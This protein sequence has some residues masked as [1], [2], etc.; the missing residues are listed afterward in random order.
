MGKVTKKTVNTLMDVYND[1]V[2]DTILLTLQNPADNNSVVAEIEVKNQLTIAEKGA[3]V[4]RVVNACFDEDGEYMPEYL[5]PAFAITL[6]QMTTKVPVYEKTIQDD[7]GNDMSIVDIGRTFELCKAINLVTN[8]KDKV[9]SSLVSELRQMINDKLD[10]VKQINIR[11]ASNS[12]TIAK[13]M[14]DSLGKVLSANDYSQLVKQL[15]NVE[16]VKEP[17]GNVNYVG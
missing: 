13:P 6:L 15:L 2:V 3:F 17:T 9:F 16:D 1:S 11:K 14:I 10:Y 8:V 7:D 5:E 12:L 4:N